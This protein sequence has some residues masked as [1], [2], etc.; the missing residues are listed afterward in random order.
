M[1]CE[2]VK[3][4]LPANISNSACRLSFR[5]YKSVAVEEFISFFVTVSFS[6]SF[7]ICSVYVCVWL[8]LCLLCVC[9]CV[10]LSLSLSLCTKKWSH[11]SSS[12]I[13][14][15]D[16]VVVLRLLVGYSLRTIVSAIMISV[17]LD[18]SKKTYFTCLGVLSIA[19][20]LLSRIISV[21]CNLRK[22]EADGFRA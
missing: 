15:V 3:A 2:S 14:Y 20:G 4:E 6:L 8:S 13:H 10:C 17:D 18:D 16:V 7:C 22:E 11:H 5:H 12:S 19:Q 21:H 1:P 9:V